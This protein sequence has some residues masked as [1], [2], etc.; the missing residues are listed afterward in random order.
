MKSIFFDIED[1]IHEE[2]KIHCVKEKSSIKEMLT[3]MIKDLLD[4]NSV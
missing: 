2:F 1:E 3:E 4:A